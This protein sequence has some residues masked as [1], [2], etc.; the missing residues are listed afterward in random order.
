MIKLRRGDA[1]LFDVNY[2][3]PINW[4]AKLCVKYGHIA[5]Y[6]DETKR[7]LP[8]IAESIGRGAIIRSLYS[9][10]G[11]RVMVMRPKVTDAQADDIAHAAEHIADNPASWYGYFDIPRFVLPKIIL[12]KIGKI[13]PMKWNLL[14][15]ALAYSYKHN[16]AVICSEFYAESCKN[17]GYP[18]CSEATIPLPDDIATSGSLEEIGWTVIEPSERV[19]RWIGEQ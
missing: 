8:L 19:S 11:R 10:T 16:S 13:L 6:Y 7:G 3:K 14:F 17:A 4:L 5:M 15:K 18:V 12:L 9:Y 1:L 2:W